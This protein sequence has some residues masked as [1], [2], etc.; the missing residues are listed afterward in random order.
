MTIPGALLN[1]RTD[2][3]ANPQLAPLDT[4]VKPTNMLQFDLPTP[5]ED[6]RQQQH[7]FPAVHGPKF[8]TPNATC[9]DDNGF[10]PYWMDRAEPKVSELRRP[11]RLSILR[12]KRNSTQAKHSVATGMLTPPALSEGSA[13]NSSSESSAPSPAPL[14]EAEGH[15]MRI[16]R[17]I[18]TLLQR[19]S[20][21][22]RRADKTPST[23]QVSTAPS[24]PKPSEE[25]PRRSQSE[26]SRR[27]RV[28]EA[29]R[30]SVSLDSGML[31]K[32]LSR[33]NTQTAE[34]PLASA[35]THE[36]DCAFSISQF[37]VTGGN[38]IIPPLIGKSIIHVKVV[39]D[40]DTCIVVPMV[41]NIVFAR[42]RE[43]IL[44]K[45]FQCGVPFVASK[46]LRLVVRRPEDGSVVSVVGDN[47]AWRQLMDA[48]VRNKHRLCGGRPSGEF[49]RTSEDSDGAMVADTRYVIKL[50]LHL[51]HP[52]E[53]PATVLEQ[54]Q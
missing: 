52:G 50:T 40:K 10:T 7:E 26:E 32:P 37:K 19:S 20:S 53:I 21:F 9:S 34:R 28:F 45:L 23:T 46:A 18:S 15:A 30:T 5:E 6:E 41:R 25:S 24:S 13:S 38:C 42:A 29:L 47:P 51:V 17:S 22:M 14:E 11:S 36:T 44:T 8:P 35:E 2:R 16:K 1:R 49:P 27:S 43:R 48:A 3:F 31:R 12:R 33:K 54:T 39:V 4:S